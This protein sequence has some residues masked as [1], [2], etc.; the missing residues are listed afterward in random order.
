M[1]T[2]QVKNKYVKIKIGASDA[3]VAGKT[4]RAIADT[5]IASH[6]SKQALFIARKIYEQ[7]STN[8]K[9]QKERHGKVN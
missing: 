2:K 4:S 9:H 5:L 1:T 7:C 3:I 6:G 8:Y